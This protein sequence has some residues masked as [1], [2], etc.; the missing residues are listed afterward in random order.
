MVAPK[1]LAGS[2]LFFHG[3]IVHGSAANMSPFA[4]NLVLVT[5]NHHEN[6]PIPTKEPRPEFLASRDYR[7]VE[8]LAETAL[9]S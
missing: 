9:S 4:R 1:G 3:N 6:I 8:P 2:V 7:P 5:F